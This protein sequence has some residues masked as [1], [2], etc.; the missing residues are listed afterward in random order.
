[1]CIIYDEKSRVASVTMVMTQLY[2]DFILCICP[3]SM[4][5]CYNEGALSRMRMSI[6]YMYVCL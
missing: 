6:R 5:G 4:N 3:K 2:S 1:M